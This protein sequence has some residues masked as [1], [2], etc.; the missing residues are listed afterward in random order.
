M[1]AQL[2]VSLG[3]LYMKLKCI[4]MQFEHYKNFI[5][6]GLLTPMMQEALDAWALIFWLHLMHL[7]GRQNNTLVY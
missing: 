5:Y 1:C 2:V 7:E 4:A 3:M 6:L